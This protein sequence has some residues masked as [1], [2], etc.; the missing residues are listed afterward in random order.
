MIREGFL[1]AFNLLISGDQQVFDAAFRSIWIS[2]AAVLAASVFGITA[3][4]MLARKKIWGHQAWVLCARVGMSVPTVLIG[5]LLFAVFSRRGT[6]G[7]LE[8]LYTSY[9]VVIGEF[10]L[11]LPIVISLTHA[12]IAKLDIVVFESAKT[13]GARPL[14]RAFT[15]IN[16]ARLAIIL[17]ILT[18]FS[19][20]FTELGIAMM[21]GGNIADRTRTLTTAVAL[22]TARGE[23]SRGIAMCFIL[24]LLALLTTICITWIGRTKSEQT[25][26][27]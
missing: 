18:A 20:C 24:V 8:F 19:R 12:A 27:E 5:L 9:A 15:Y 22:E 14:K 16:E 4:V 17:A 6:L 3:G 23:F 26:H 11:A 10:L 25:C 21:V 7:S 13:L 2:I 1:E